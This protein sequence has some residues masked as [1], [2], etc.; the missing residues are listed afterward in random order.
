LRILK[1]DAS[2]ANIRIVIQRT[3]LSADAEDLNVL[4]EEARRKGVSLAS[5][6]AEVVQREAAAL[7]AS[8]RPRIGIVDRRVS[9]AQAM[10]NEPDAAADSEF[11]FG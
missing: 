7:R 9:I 6:L 3:T 8:R 4:K 1:Y 2:E 5:L 10:D 11:R